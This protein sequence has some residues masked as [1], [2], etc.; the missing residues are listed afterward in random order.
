MF[1]NKVAMF[2]ALAFAG[3]LFASNGPVENGKISHA[4][5]VLH[6]ANQACIKLNELAEK[7]AGSELVKVYARGMA[8]QHAESDAKLLLI[9]KKF[10][11]ELKDPEPQTPEGK[12][13][14]ERAEAESKLLNSLEG[15]A[16]DKE[17]LALAMTA[18]AR[19]IR[20]L[21]K[22]QEA[23][24]EPEVKTFVG[25]LIT[26]MRNHLATSQD[27]ERKITEDSI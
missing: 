19:V 13:L 10:G 2:I 5:S 24:Q 23:A 17:Y 20:F 8:T 25:D 16:W 6:F 26:I 14:V 21:E 4:F 1:K 27:V 7:R 22:K 9:A 18:Q 3:T 15:D 11:I 12:S